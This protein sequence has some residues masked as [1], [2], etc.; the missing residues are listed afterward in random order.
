VGGREEGG[1]EEKGLALLEPAEFR[2]GKKGK[3][4]D[5][6]S[7]SRV[8][9]RLARDTEK[10]RKEMGWQWSADQ[11]ATNEKGSGHDLNYPA[12]SSRKTER[13]KKKKKKTY[14][15]IPLKKGK[16]KGKKI[17]LSP[18][19]HSRKTTTP[20]GRPGGGEKGREGFNWPSKGGGKKEER[21]FIIFLSKRRRQ[22]Y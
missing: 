11:N 12:I 13:R 10:G 16:R 20:S 9:P 17:S 6:S 3:R 18:E 7:T 4:E 19:R 5:C 2:R 14:A 21:M 1:G 15:T 22:Y 8:R